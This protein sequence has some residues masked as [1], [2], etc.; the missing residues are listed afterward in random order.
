MSGAA[1]RSSFLDTAH[2]IDGGGGARR[3]QRAH[4]HACMHKCRIRGILTAA[5]KWCLNWRE[6]FEALST[7][8][9]HDTI[10][11]LQ[12]REGD[13]PICLHGLNVR[14]IRASTKFDSVGFHACERACS[15]STP[16]TLGKRSAGRQAAASM[17]SMCCAAL[18]CTAAAA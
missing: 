8:M 3:T 17:P 6:A 5:L 1:Q 18:H 15:A 13:T 12:S 16:A 7:I 9:W 4:M 11:M 2:T 14:P 10:V